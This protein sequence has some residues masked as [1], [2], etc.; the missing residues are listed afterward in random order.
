MFFQD[1]NDAMP[2]AGIEIKVSYHLALSKIHKIHEQVTAAFKHLQIAQ[3]Q[4]VERLCCKALG[5]MPSAAD[6]T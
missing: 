5:A 2:S 1:R 6:M 4:G 3:R